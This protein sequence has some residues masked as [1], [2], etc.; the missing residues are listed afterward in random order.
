MEII[1]KKG[2]GTRI[3]TSPRIGGRN[4]RVR[5]S[6]SLFGMWRREEKG[7]GQQLDCGGLRLMGDDPTKGG[8]RL[9]QR[10]GDSI[11]LYR[12]EGGRVCVRKGEHV[13]RKAIGGKVGAMWT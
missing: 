10:K 4:A 11:S 9:P 7:R 13:H 12:G 8:V 1:E 3:M 2:N 5:I 6:P